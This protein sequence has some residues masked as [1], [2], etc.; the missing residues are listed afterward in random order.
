MQRIDIRKAVSGDAEAITKLVNRSYRPASGIKGWTH[1]SALVKGDRTNIKTMTAALQNTTVL[2]G[3]NEDSVIV[4]CVQIEAHGRQAH[5]GMLAVDPAQQSSGMGKLLLEG[6]E[7]FAV[8]SIQAEEAILT[9]I[10]AR[11]EL[12]D[13]YLRRGYTR[14]DERLQYPIESG[15]GMPSEAAM[16]LIILKKTFND[17]AAYE[18]D[19]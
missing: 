10:A 2:I 16:D 19:N 8:R 3:V 15:V 1:E 7:K 9:V 13:Y 18:A 14:T 5:I 17:V 6:A 11:T 4:G 12:I